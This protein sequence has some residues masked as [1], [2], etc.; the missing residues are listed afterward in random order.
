[1]DK[2]LREM[3]PKSICFLDPLPDLV[4]YI[5]FFMSQKSLYNAHFIRPWLIFLIFSAGWAWWCPVNKYPTH[6]GGRDYI[7]PTRLIQSQIW[8]NKRETSF[9]VHPSFV[10]IKLQFNKVSQKWIINH[11]NSESLEDGRRV[12][13]CSIYG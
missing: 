11:R 12:S 2:R 1:M 6:K 4:A 5:L 10:N 7:N 13:R 8:I 9:R 3:S